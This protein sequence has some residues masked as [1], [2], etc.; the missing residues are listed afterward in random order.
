[1]P[2]AR[3]AKS[4]AESCHVTST[5]DVWL[6]LGYVAISRTFKTVCYAHPMKGHEILAFRI[7]YKIKLSNVNSGALAGTSSGL[8]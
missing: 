8:L 7:L 3:P 4:Q 5:A 6:Q 1:M 2:R